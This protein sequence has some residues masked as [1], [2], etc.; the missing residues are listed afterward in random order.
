[1]TPAGLWSRIAFGAA[2]AAALPLT[3]D[4]PPPT[5]LQ[6]PPALAL[7]A[8]LVVGTCLFSALARRRPPG[9]VPLSAAQA[10]FVAGWAAVEETLW[11]WL[12][13]G[14][15]AFVIPTSAAFVAATATFALGHAHGRR[16][17]LGTGSTFGS[18]YL[19]TGTL[20]APVAAHIVYNLLIAGSLRV[21]R[22][23]ARA[24]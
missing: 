13:L 14:G 5:E 20:L 9:H 17:H 24:G 23:E 21:A 16:V 22:A 4:I 11:R 1:M 3:L 8:G 7:A 12:L 19:L 15:L 18:L 2:L 10:V 6:V